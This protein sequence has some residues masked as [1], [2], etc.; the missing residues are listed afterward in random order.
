[1]NS[2]LW[3]NLAMLISQR[4]PISVP[5][6]P[7]CPNLEVSSTTTR[8][9]D[10]TDD[11]VVASLVR[12]CS[13]HGKFYGKTLIRNDDWDYDYTCGFKTECKGQ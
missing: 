12:L 1:M 9:W 3:F 6:V 8:A 5:T 13:S 10:S 2:L 11:V 7:G 4:V